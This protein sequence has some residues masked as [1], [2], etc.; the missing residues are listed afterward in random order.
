VLTL[1]LPP[2]DIDLLGLEVKM[3]EPITVK[4]SAVEANGNLL[5]NVLTSV[6][7]LLNTQGIGAALSNVLGNI[8]TLLISTDLM[9]GGVGTGEFDTA[10]TSATPVLD[11]FVAPVRVD[12]LGALVET[13]PIHLTITAHA[14]EGLVLGNVLTALSDLF[15]PPLP[16]PLD[17]TFIND[18]L[19]QL[20]AA[21]NAQ[22]PGIP[23]TES[24]PP[25]LGAGDILALTVPAINLDLLGLVLQTT[26][27]TVNAS[28]SSGDGQLLGN[29]LT[30][31]L[32]TLNAT[33]EELTRLNA[34]INAI[35]AK[36]V[37]VLNNAVL[38]LPPDVLSNLSAALQT[39]AL[40]DLIT[41]EPGATA[42]ILDLTLASQT[43]TPVTVDLLGLHVSAESN[44]NWSNRMI[45]YLTCSESMRPV[46]ARAEKI[47]TR[48]RASHRVEEHGVFSGHARRRRKSPVC[49]GAKRFA[50]RNRPSIPCDRGARRGGSRGLDDLRD[51]RE[52][53]I[54]SEFE[55]YQNFVVRPIG[56][57]LV[58]QRPNLARKSEAIKS[59]AEQIY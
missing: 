44:R 40:P 14:G 59:F 53:E 19:E 27:I 33:P 45:S 58:N 31:V 1:T 16:D 29:I 28:A 51:V 50:R 24:P 34:T 35:L 43:G 41:V 37:G 11:L 52:Y 2:L 7:S 38:I 39:L 18:R 42:S 54:H 13:S 15:D 10:P 26:P 49:G 17:L 6:S 23:P 32:D 5:G 56:L 25:V 9:V 57:A 47:A 21:V 12:L 46:N 3:A 30:S 48:V 22:I 4:I 36:V 8:V 55:D 20:L